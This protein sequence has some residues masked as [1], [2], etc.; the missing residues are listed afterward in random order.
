LIFAIINQAP[1]C[2]CKHIIMTVIEM[3]EDNQV[4]LPFGGLVK[5]ILKKKLTNIAANELEDMPDGPFGKMTIMKSNAQLQRFQEQDDPVPPAHA[6]PLVA[7]SSH[8]ESSGDAVLS[9]LAQIT[10]RLQSTNTRMTDQFQSMDN[11]LLSLDDHFQLMEADV[12]QIKINE[13]NILCYVLPENQRDQV[14]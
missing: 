1:F 12:A 7:F 13:R 6:T 5:K 14:P 10:D 8:A 4:V 2:M 11:R 9:M 3:Q